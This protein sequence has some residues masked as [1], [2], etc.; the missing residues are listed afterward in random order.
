[1]L[2]LSVIGGVRVAKIYKIKK[3][4]CL[5]VGILFLILSLITHTSCFTFGFIS[6]IGLAGW[7]LLPDKEGD[8]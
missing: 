4:F 8:V 3:K 1:M 2:V 7:K 6:G 5:I